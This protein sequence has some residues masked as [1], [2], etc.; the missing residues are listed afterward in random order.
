MCLNCPFVFAILSENDV[1]LFLGVVSDPSK[2]DDRGCVGTKMTKILGNAPLPT[3]SH[4]EFTL[5]FL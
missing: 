1:P 4:P 3:K 2:L 5:G